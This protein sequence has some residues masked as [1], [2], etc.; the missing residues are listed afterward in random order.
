M[1]RRPKKT[2]PYPSEAE[3]ARTLIQ[4]RDD[5]LAILPMYVRLYKMGLEPARMGEGVHVSGGDPS[6]V[7]YELTV[8]ARPTDTADEKKNAGARHVLSHRDYTKRVA[9]WIQKSASDIAR[10]RASLERNVGPVPGYRQSETLGSD[11]VGVTL[12]QW[13]EGLEKQAARLRQGGE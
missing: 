11:H 4:V 1:T 2:E 13:N 8:D 7:P 6:N 3:F 10:T 9:G 5:L 12:E